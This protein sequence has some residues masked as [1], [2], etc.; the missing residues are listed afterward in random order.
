M[1][2]VILTTAIIRPNI[3][4]Q[5]FSSLK[6]FITLK[7]KIY[8]I[9]NLDFVNIFDNNT[10]IT[11][12]LIEKCLVNTAKNIQKIFLLYKNIKF[13]F[14]YNKKGNFNKAVRNLVNEI[15]PIINK[16]NKAILYFEDDWIITKNI[17]KIDYYSKFLIINEK[18]CGLRFGFGDSNEHSV[19]FRPSLWKIDFFKKIF[20]STF[21]NDDNIKKDPETMVRDNF[22]QISNNKI[23]LCIP[24]CLMVNDIGRLW[25]R[26]LN[27]IKWDRRNPTT[28]ITY[29]NN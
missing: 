18:Y 25:A 28:D 3:H 21:D 15:K 27:L 23:F 22:K 6:K 12:K 8:W 26:K 29:I 2:Y 24:Q 9:I 10:K 5:S 13:K 14:I 1:D 11:D 7:D 17:G 4:I 16:I 19:S 20:I